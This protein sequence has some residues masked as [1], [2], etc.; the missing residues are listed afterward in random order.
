MYE[1]NLW[2]A[3]HSIYG[4]KKKMEEGLDVDYNP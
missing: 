2:R 1:H 3:K 4:V